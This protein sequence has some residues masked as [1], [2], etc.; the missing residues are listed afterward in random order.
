MARAGDHPRESAKPGDVASATAVAAPRVVRHL[1]S[2][3]TIRITEDG[4]R[5]RVRV[6]GEV[7]LDCADT[8]HQAL[9]DCLRATPHGVDVDLTGA[10]FF[11]CAG[12]NALLRARARAHDAGAELNVTAVSPAVARV[13][14]LTHCAEAFP[15][16]AAPAPVPLPAPAQ[17]LVPWG[18]PRAARPA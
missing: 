16:A 13:L 3:L 15:H 1:R 6:E 17:P 10:E 14:D 7:D 4:D 8:L 2:G 12:L 5:T 9:A 18:T 11:D